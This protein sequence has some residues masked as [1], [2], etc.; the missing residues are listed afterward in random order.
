MHLR[1]ETY[2]C[3]ITRRDDFRTC[4]KTFHRR[5]TFETHLTSKHEVHDDKRIKEKVESCCV[6]LDCP[7]EFQCP[8]CPNIIKNES[9][10]WTARFDHIEE[11][12]DKQRNV[13]DENNHE[14][15]ISKPVQEGTARQADQTFNAMWP[16]T[17]VTLDDMGLQIELLRQQVIDLRQNQPQ[18]RECPDS[19]LNGLNSGHREVWM[20]QEVQNLMDLVM[21]YGKEKVIRRME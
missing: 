2:T 11:H 1:I 19:S 9:G 4:S 12:F 8:L 16:I 17:E 20:A 13:Q 10:T 3:D 6:I 5:G 15:S 14:E 18:K 21:K 7:R